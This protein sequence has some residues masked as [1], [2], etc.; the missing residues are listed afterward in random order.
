MKEVALNDFAAQWA[1]VRSRAL[2][3]VDRVGRSGWL[4]LG[5]EVAAFEEA[6]AR[7]W[8]LSFAVSGMMIPPAVF[9]SS[10]TLRTRTRS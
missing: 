7:Y 10:S 5:S 4:V 8:G 9:S 2:E 3:A 6:L 1:R